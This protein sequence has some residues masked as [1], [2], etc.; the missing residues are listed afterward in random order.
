MKPY[1]QLAMPRR[2][3]ARQ[4]ERV[5]AAIHASPQGRCDMSVADASSSLLNYCF[6]ILWARLHTDLRRGMPFTHWAIVHDDIA[7]PPGWVDSL[8]EILD[9]TGGDFVSAHMPIKTHIGVMS[10]GVHYGDLWDINRFTVRRLAEF[11]ETFTSDEVNGNLILNTGCCVLRIRDPWM[12]NPKDFLF[13]DLNRLVERDGELKAECISEDWTWTDKLRNAGA[14][15]VAT[16]KVECGHEGG[17]VYRNHTIWGEWTSDQS[18]EKRHGI[19]HE[20]QVP[21]ELLVPTER[22][23]TEPA[24]CGG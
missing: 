10:M 17:H 12:S 1:V 5:G 11:P 4:E 14:K 18:Y 24:V 21:S 19:K 22:Q 23:N 15:L 8:V 16:R 13:D 3:A 2:K 9:Q 7:T 20:D 6:N